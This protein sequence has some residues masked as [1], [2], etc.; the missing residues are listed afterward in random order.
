MIGQQVTDDLVYEGPGGKIEP[1]LATGWTVSPNGLKYVFTIKQGV[2]FTDG[3]P[4]ERCCGPRRTS[5]VSWI[6]RP[7][8]RPTVDTSRRSMQTPKVLGTYLLEVDLKQ[9]D[10]ALLDVLAQGY[11]GIESPMPAISPAVRR[12]TATIR[13]VP[14]RSRSRATRRTS[15]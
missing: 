6:R 14:G 15:R 8:P 2:T 4:L 11:I 1:W 12:R 13:S 3:T 5:T 9:A 7:A 10:T